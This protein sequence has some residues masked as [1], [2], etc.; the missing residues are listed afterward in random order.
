MMAP[1]LAPRSAARASRVWLAGWL[2]QLIGRSVLMR[3]VFFVDEGLYM[4]GNLDL[5]AFVVAALVASQHLGAIDNAHL[6]RVGK[7]SENAPNVTVRHRVI[8]EIEA[9][10]GVFAD[11]NLYAFE[12]WHRVVGQRQQASRFLGEHFTHGAALGIVGALA[13]CRRTITPGCGL[14]IEI[15]NVFE[16]A[17]GEEGVAYVA[18]GALHAAFFVAARDRDGARFVT[19]MAGKI[20]QGGMEADRIAAP[21]QHRAFKIIV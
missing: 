14:L 19:V 6:M 5:F 3:R 20:Q 12:Q 17:G 1:R 16:A 4:G 8:I 18:N 2:C 10:I 9:N 13:I 21:L 11:R 7:N 15:V